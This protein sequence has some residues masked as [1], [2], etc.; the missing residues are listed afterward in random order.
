MSHSYS[1]GRSLNAAPNATFEQILEARLSRRGLLKG[2]AALA[3]AS[4]LPLSLGACATT[5]LR[6]EGR[7]GFS[8]ITVSTADAVRVPAGYSAKVL[9]AWGDP[10]GHPSA[11]PAFRHDAGNSAGEQALQA[12][13][14]HDGIHY[15]PLPYGSENSASGLLV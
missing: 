13:M 10:V 11:S 5:G 3:A 14:H 8:G 2:A 1:D 7:L 15:F 6:R 12:G 9:Y 4:A